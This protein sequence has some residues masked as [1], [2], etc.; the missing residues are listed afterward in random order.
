MT[1]RAGQWKTDGSEDPSFGDKKMTYSFSAVEEDADA[2]RLAVKTTVTKPSNFLYE[3]EEPSDRFYLQAIVEEK[4]RSSSLSMGVAKHSNFRLGYGTKGMLYNGNLTN[5]IAALKT[6]Y[7]PFLQKGDAVV[8][9]YAVL[10]EFIEVK[11]HVNGECL[12]I[13]FRVPKE[14]EAFLP[15]LSMTGELTLQIKITLDMPEYA[16]TSGPDGS[17]PS[18]IGT[19]FKI[20]EAQDET[21]RTI[22]PVEGGDPSKI[23]KVT[24]VPDG[25]STDQASLIVVVFNILSIGELSFFK[26]E[27][28]IKLSSVE[29]GHRVTST[30]RRPPE[31]YL[32]VEKSMSQCMANGWASME[33]SAHGKA[34]TIKNARGQCVAKGEK[35]ERQLGSPAL[36]SY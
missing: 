16:A 18:I 31:P 17:E 4:H 12:G 21:G 22:V 6:G 35:L 36:T 33:M 13:G 14:D 34:L 20:T 27:T 19:P 10:G 28:G 8:V 5:G 32:G 29:G 15:V 2:Q 7:A 11:H 30:R 1:V 24:I 3:L 26:S 25:E 9:E 23:I